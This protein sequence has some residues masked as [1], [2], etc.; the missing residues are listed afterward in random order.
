MLLRGCGDHDTAEGERLVRDAAE[1]GV[2]EAR[3]MLGLGDLFSS[4]KL[5]EGRIEDVEAVYKRGQEMED[6]ELCDAEDMWIVLDSYKTAAL[7]GNKKAAE[8]YNEL[9]SSL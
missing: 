9:S 1:D 4:L 8:K 2:M 7:A 6:H 3:E 5:R